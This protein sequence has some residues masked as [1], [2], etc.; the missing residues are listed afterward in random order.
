MRRL[1]IDHQV[2][3]AVSL[4]AL[5]MALL[6]ALL[7]SPAAELPSL[8]DSPSLVAASTPRPATPQFN[9][10]LRGE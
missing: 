9:A 8:Q 3:L 5:D 6:L 10:A 2:R 4:I 7:G 1:G